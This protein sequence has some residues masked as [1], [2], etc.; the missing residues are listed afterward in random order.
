MRR[1]AFLIGFL[2]LIFGLVPLSFGLVAGASTALASPQCWDTASGLTAKVVAKSNQL[3]GGVIDATGCDVGVYVGAGVTG[4]LIQHATISNANDEAILV[5]DTWD[6]GIANNT[7]IH[8]DVAVHT[9]IAEDKAISLVGSSHVTVD[10]NL[11]TDTVGSGGIGVY[12]DGA[13]DP[14]GLKPGM[15]LP[16]NNNWVTDN[17]VVNN[18]TDCGIIVAAFNAGKT[19]GVSGNVIQGNTVSNNVSGIVLAANGPGVVVSNNYVLWNTVTDNGINGIILHSNA[20]GS[21]ISG[22]VIHR[23]TV[24]GNGADPE[25][26]L[27]HPNGIILAGSTFGPNT[28]PAVVTN[29]YVT[30]NWVKNEYFGVAEINAQNSSVLGWALIHATVPVF[31]TP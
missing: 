16:G 20:P 27:T 4:V 2:S 17:Q 5:Q 29:T 10:H 19:G 7:V 23:N 3:I 8:N 13:V 14:S 18:L 15:S 6:V 25:V 24:S 21:A 22:T 11:V 31:T 9:S 28:P 12:D 26:G 30:Y 1:H